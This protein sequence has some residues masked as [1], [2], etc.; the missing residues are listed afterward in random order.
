MELQ[1]TL[2]SVH[3]ASGLLDYLQA[4]LA[5]SRHSKWLQ[6]GLSPRAGMALLRATRAWALLSHRDFVLPEDIQAVLPSVV[7]HRLQPADEHLDDSPAELARHLI[8]S[9]SLPS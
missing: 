4:I 2:A 3:L 5:F 7:G 1:S 6:G 9:V 8:A